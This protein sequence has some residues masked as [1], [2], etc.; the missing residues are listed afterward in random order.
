[1]LPSTTSNLTR[2]QLRLLS[3]RHEV[4][5]ELFYVQATTATF[6]TGAGAI[7]INADE[8]VRFPVGEFQREWNLCDD[9]VI[10]FASDASLEYSD[11]KRASGRTRLCWLECHK[12][13]IGLH[14]ELCCCLEASLALFDP[15][16]GVV[17][18]EHALIEC[19]KCD[20]C[21]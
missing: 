3:H 21:M 8:I 20:C 15:D 4:Q 6:E 12:F 11:S 9:R 16:R 14:A 10:A 2:R 7:D 13:R 19:I 5:E 18:R 1:M 17:Q